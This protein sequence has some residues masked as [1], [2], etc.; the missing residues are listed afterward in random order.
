MHGVAAGY[1]IIDTCHPTAYQNKVPNMSLELS[2]D[3]YVRL[4]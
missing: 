4:Q 1:I 2:A 3:T